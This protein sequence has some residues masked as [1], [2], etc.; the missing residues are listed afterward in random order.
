VRVPSAS[1]ALAALIGVFI[2]AASWFTIR[3]AAAL[4]SGDYVSCTVGVDF[5]VQATRVIES[6]VFP[7]RATHLV[8]R[9]LGR[10]SYVSECEYWDRYVP[11]ALAVPAAACLIPVVRRAR[12]RPWR[13]LAPRVDLARRWP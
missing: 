4:A 11:G 3:T 12:R 9:T 13:Y 1:V 8:T 7:P 2:V 5:D 6:E 10:G